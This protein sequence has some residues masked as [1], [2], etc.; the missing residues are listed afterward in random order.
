MR[1]SPT[2]SARGFTLVEI[3]VVLTII[4]FLIG[5][6]VPGYARLMPHL[7]LL[8]A[9]HRLLAD[10]RHAHS[11]A[12]ST[13]RTVIVAFDPAAGIYSADGREETIA[14]KLSLSSGTGEKPV[15]VRFFADGSATP[16]RILLSD[17]GERSGIL[18]DAFTGRAHDAAP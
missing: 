16:A 3:L 8:S 4:G 13:D 2:G 1:T 9:K 18:V 6:C 5:I 15:A 12:V 11:E 10:L 7:R 14:V 17:G